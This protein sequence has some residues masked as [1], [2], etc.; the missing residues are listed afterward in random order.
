M[1]ENDVVISK[2]LALNT[3]SVPRLVSINIATTTVEK[4]IKSVQ[5]LRPVV[6]GRYI[7]A[8][9]VVAFLGDEDRKYTSSCGVSTRIVILNRNDTALI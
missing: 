6:P 7:L 2:R 3:M 9:I 4:I 5:I 8:V 1:K